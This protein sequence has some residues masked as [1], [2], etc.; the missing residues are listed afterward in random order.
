MMR[1]VK[2]AA[3]ALTLLTM[4]VLAHPGEKVDHIEYK[5]LAELH[6]RV[7]AEGA[8][9]LQQCSG[10]LEARQFEEENI[11]RRHAVVQELRQ[12]AGLPALRTYIP[13]YLSR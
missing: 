1:I 3:L 12:S 7:A 6:R 9:A 5:R 2:L 10:S 4:S 11:A 13:P 8:Q